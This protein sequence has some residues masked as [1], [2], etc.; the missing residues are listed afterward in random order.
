MSSLGVLQVLEDATSTGP[1]DPMWV[2]GSN[3]G[4][5]QVT[6]SDGTFVGFTVQTSLDG[7]NWSNSEPQ[8]PVNETDSYTVLIQ[9]SGPVAYV[10]INVIEL[11][12]SSS[13]SAWI[14]AFNLSDSE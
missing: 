4:S 5:I 8:A 7:E 10:R 2:A 12:G 14:S 6:P 13:V 9:W 11:T 1:S 3:V